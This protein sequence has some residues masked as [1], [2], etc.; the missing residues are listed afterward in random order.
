MFYSSKVILPLIESPGPLQAIHRA[1]FLEVLLKHLPANYRAHF[2]KR[3]TSYTDSEAEPVLLSFKDGSTATCDLL[4]GADGIKSATRRAMYEKLA[5]AEPSAEKVTALR[6]L[7][8]PRWTGKYIYRSI[9]SSDELAKICPDHPSLNAPQFVSQTII[10]RV[11]CP[12]KRLVG[13]QFCGRRKVRNCLNT[14]ASALTV[15][16]VLSH[17][18]FRKVARSIVSP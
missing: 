9:I 10:T 5:D 6:D 13:L 17:T 3:L 16:S 1:E 12:D 18:P 11:C 2:G 8:S 14:K 15:P 7:I 4:V